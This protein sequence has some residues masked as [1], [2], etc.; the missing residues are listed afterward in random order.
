MS[1]WNG[2]F[3]G[4]KIVD[5]VAIPSYECQNYKSILDKKFVGEMSSILNADLAKGRIKYVES[6]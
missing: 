1:I 2:I 3:D 5:D 4:F 6:K